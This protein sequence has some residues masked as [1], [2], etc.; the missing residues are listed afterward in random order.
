MSQPTF[1]EKLWERKVPQLLGT[2]LAVGFGVLQFVEFISRRFSMSSF[3]IDSYLLLW[4]MLIPA[5]R[6]FSCITQGLPTQNWKRTELEKVGDIWEYGLG[7]AVGF[8]NSQQCRPFGH[9][10]G[11]NHRCGRKD[12]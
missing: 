3:W 12:H 8:V 2:Y 4:L 6:R 10:D 1:F 7:L 9:S 5:R 11:D